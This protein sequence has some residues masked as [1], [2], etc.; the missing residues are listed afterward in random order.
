L[1]RENYKPDYNR[2]QLKWLQGLIPK[3]SCLTPALISGEELVRLQFQLHARLWLPAGI[4]P[5]YYV[6]AC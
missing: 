3:Y 1:T 6:Q 5:L 4:G 2:E